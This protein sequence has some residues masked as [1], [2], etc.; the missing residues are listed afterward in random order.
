MT[1]NDDNIEVPKDPKNEISNL[2]EGEENLLPDLNEE[3]IIIELSINDI[4][5]RE[6][7]KLLA[8]EALTEHKKIIVELLIR[9]INAIERKKILELQALTEHKKIVIDLSIRDININEQNKII[10][11]QALIEKEIQN[12]FQGASRSNKD[13]VP[14]EDLSAIDKTHVNAAALTNITNQQ[15]ETTGEAH[16][17]DESHKLDGHDGEDGNN[18]SIKQSANSLEHPGENKSSISIDIKKLAK[19][20]TQNAQAFI[21]HDHHEQV[22]AKLN[23]KLKMQKDNNK[24][25][26]TP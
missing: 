4:N 15:L 20:I 25:R 13:H 12:V 26:S 14:G 7:D 18:K 11:L 2:N 5:A 23:I 22:S 16:N 6:K 1:K 21:D 3:E 9:Y 19:I 17:S 8:L 24:G 10:A